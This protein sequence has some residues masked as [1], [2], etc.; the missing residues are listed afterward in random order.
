MRII[1]HQIG[2]PALRKKQRGH[3]APKAP[4]ISLDQPGRLRV[5]NLLAIFGISHTTLYE[6]FKTGRYP[7]PDG[8]DRTFPYWKTATIKTFLDA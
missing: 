2:A 8:R 4:M 5:A 1:Q 7:R 6:G 3:T